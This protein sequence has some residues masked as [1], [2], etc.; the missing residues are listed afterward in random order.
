MQW[1]SVI[2]LEI[3][4][5][6]LSKSKIF[7]GSSTA[8]GAAANT[9]ANIIDLGMPGVLPVLNRTAVVLAG[10]YAVDTTDTVEI[11]CNTV[12]AVLEAYLPAAPSAEDVERVVAEVIAEVGASG[13]RHMGKVMKPA[14]ERLGGAADGKQVSG[15]AKK[16]LSG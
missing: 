12:R 2:G 16:L 8:F 11:H 14:L 7:S 4:T 15:V 10:G 3:H 9:Q 6:L 13:P 1:E 5:Q